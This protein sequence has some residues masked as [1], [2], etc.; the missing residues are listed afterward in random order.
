MRLSPKF[1]SPQLYVQ[2]VV[3]LLFMVL[4][5]L[6]AHPSYGQ[7]FQTVPG[8]AESVTRP[9]TS[10]DIS[11]VKPRRA[12]VSPV[13]FSI[14]IDPV[15]QE[16]KSAETATVPRPGTPHKIGFGRD[17]PQLGTAEDTA[18]HLQWRN[19][20]KMG[21][22]AAI[23]I[24]SPQA[25]GI[26]LGILVRR[27]PVEATLR[28][29]A[30]GAEAAYE[31]SGR[32]IMESIKRNLVAGD[33]SDD[34]RTY[35]SPHI[36]GAEATL[37]IELP[38]GI[39][40]DTVEISIPRVSHFFSSPL[41]A[42]GGNIIKSIGDAATCEIDATCYSDWGLESSATARML[43]VKAGSSY[44]C[45]GTLLN[46]IA[47][48][49][50]PY[51]LSANHCIS[52]QTV[53]S[54]LETYW[55]Y[56]S[57]SC[58]S[59]TLN[60]GS[61]SRTSGATLLYASPVTDTSFLK[62]NSA[63]P[64]G[65]V[66]AGW[67]KTVPVLG[68]DVTGVHHP[69]G[70]L[71]KISF[72]SVKGFQDCTIPDPNS[73]V[74]TCTAPTQTSAEYLNITFNSG[75]TEGGSSG[76]GLFKT[77]GGS[78]YLIGQL[79]G[80]NTDCINPKGSDSYGR[81]DVAYTAKLHEW[82][83]AGSTFSLSI[84]KPGN[85]RGTVTSEPSGIN[86]GT[87]CSAPFT[88]GSS[89]AL[90]AASASGSTFTGWS[91]ACSGTDASCSLVMN[92]DKSVT[93]TFSTIDAISLGDALD[94][95][96]LVWTTGGDAPFTAQ[97]TTSYSG[98]SAAQTGKIGDRQSTYLATNVTG[99]GTLSFYWK[100]SSEQDY[101]IFSVYLDGVREYYWSGNTSWYKTAITIPAGTHTVKWEYVKDSYDASGQDAGW[102]DNV[103]FIQGGQ[104]CSF[105]LSPKGYEYDPLSNT[106][107]IFVTASSSIC[108]WTATSNDSWIT[109]TSGSSG[110]GS[111]IVSYSVA[112]N[113]G[114]ARTGTLTIGGQTFTVTQ[115]STDVPPPS[116]DGG[117]GGGSG[118]FIATAAF[119]SP[120][121]RHVQILRD[122]RDRYLLDYR[123]GH[124]AVKLYY[125]TSPPIAE[126]IAKSEKLRLMTR[127]CLMPVVGIAYLTVS[128]GIITTLLIITISFL[129]L[130]SI[131]WIPR[132]RFKH[133]RQSSSARCST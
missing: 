116:S 84:S 115:A 50:T 8:R 28:F 101:D 61:T 94:N 42:Q 75:I 6:I 46:D 133:D 30:Q 24:T 87:A 119:G 44:L 23:S 80:G 65:A 1:E 13:P 63:P 89:V 54:T 120:M 47:S 132:K 58:N 34:A 26:R 41:A 21:N 72:G 73:P 62:L 79:F 33:S 128:F 117:G 109:S 35:W 74:M 39:S 64:A 98:G 19:T 37:E 22:I 3:A 5:T 12:G 122:F 53:A 14:S 76:S 86:C 25:V 10:N 78:H 16:K 100:V 4:L 27:L 126:T 11:P 129:I 59:G 70:D 102:V 114:T 52:K 88:G 48:S 17:V 71:Q 36:E 83:N 18:S 118:C 43:Y 57:A 15:S 68:T 38:P 103:V 97:T 91:G 66:Y 56:R 32:E 7:S 113:S 67:D 105:T 95:T 29:Y 93:A 96:N 130:G 45:S 125:H 60:P 123:L 55:F 92:A 99:P 107:R 110:T 9:A 49:G 112:A 40:P 131:I 82:L 106:G 124:K 77:S 104:D 51:F 69:K 31:I 85:G 121:E 111:G 127:W 90:T 2:N 81:F 108:S 20:P